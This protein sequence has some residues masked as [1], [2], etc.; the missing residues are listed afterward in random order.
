MTEYYAQHSS[1]VVIP[2]ILLADSKEQI[3]TGTRCR[4]IISETHFTVEID[5]VF[6]RVKKIQYEKILAW[7]AQTQRDKWG[8]SYV[9]KMGDRTLVFVPET[10]IDA[11]SISAKLMENVMNIM[12][13]RKG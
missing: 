2:V 13:A 8:F 11:G 3:T 7:S 12:S 10:Q 6:S 5:R 1:D 4:L 9:G